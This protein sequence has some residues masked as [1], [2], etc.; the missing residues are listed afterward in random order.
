MP[1]TTSPPA[2]SAPANHRAGPDDLRLVLF[3]MPAA[4]KSSLLGALSRAAEAQENLLG[5]KLI[6]ETQGLAELRHQLYETTPRRT[7]EEVVP[8][9]VRYEPL[10]SGHKPGAAV[11]AVLMDCDGRVAND[12]LVRR[13]Q[14]DEKSPEGTLAHEVLDADTLILVI[15]ASAPPAQ[16]EADFAEFVRFVRTIERGRKERTE[17]AG[18]PVFLVLTKCDLL[19][20]PGDSPADWMDRIEQRKRE[21]DAHF[22]EFVARQE[23]ESPSPPGPR[24]GEELARRASESGQRGNQAEVSPFGSIELH[25]WATAVKRPALAGSPAKPR[26]PYGVAELFRQCF[27]EAAEYRHRT[28]RATFRLGLLVAGLVGLLVLMGGT[29]VTLILTAQSSQ[30]SQLSARVEDF[31]VLTRGSLED[32]LRG[33]PGDLRDR[34]ARLEGIREHAQ[35]GRLKTEQQQFVEG[36]M[37]ELTSYLDYYEKILKEP[38]ITNERSEES[39][40]RRLARLDNELALPKEWQKTRAGEL[41]RALVTSSEAV[42]DAARTARNAYLAARDRASDVLTFRK[43]DRTLGIDWGDWTNQA[44]AEI[45]PNN[46]PID[47]NAPLP[48]YPALTFAS[49]LR[50]DSVLEARTQW[51]ADRTRVRR[52]LDICSA[53]GLAKETTGRPALLLFIGGFTAAQARTRVQDLE[54]HYPDYENT[55]VRAA[56]PD[57]IVA[58]VHQVA[59]NQYQALLGPGR[60]EV[61]RQLRVGKEGETT[62]KWQKVREWLRSPAELE[63]WRVLVRTLLRLAEA[64][65]RDPVRDLA[66]FLGKDEFVVAPRTLVLEIPENRNVE[67]RSGAPLLIEQRG[68]ATVTLRFAPSGEGQRDTE[69]RVWRYT[70]Q[71]D[72]RDRIVFKP[73]DNLWGVVELQGGKELLMWSDARSTLYLVERLRNPPRIHP[74]GAKFGSGRLVD[75]ARL[76][77]RPDDSVPRIPDLLPTVRGE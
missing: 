31:R 25:I 20:R 10:P 65:P 1:E 35:F 69:R 48:D 43:Y 75:G 45:S 22:R 72:K 12:L 15:D 39:I 52:L 18:L 55:F 46:R 21:V 76:E 3:G 60:A 34:L 24:T 13:K 73:G 17:V 29:I 49:V 23:P 68:S 50:F 70:Y 42:L 74:V 54:K 36:R 71:L 16:V 6:D 19:A 66:D 28:R 7:P 5:G 38:P 33:T 2:A 64:S 8:Y 56:L 58:K 37:A 41:H 40:D 57:A 61:L 9:T 27:E 62:Q 26:E 63:A 11:D 14:L 32:R 30:L 47:E 44:L 67:L 4:G 53:L 51:E 77:I 59:V